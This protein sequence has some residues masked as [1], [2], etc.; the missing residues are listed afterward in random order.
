MLINEIL[1]PITKKAFTTV[2]KIAKAV[3]LY[4][5]RA[6]V[7]NLKPL[8]RLDPIAAR[9]ELTIMLSQLKRFEDEFPQVKEVISF[10]ESQQHSSSPNQVLQMA[11]D[12][13]RKITN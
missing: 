2:P 13:I 11:V 4:K 6:V 10:I 1:G 8:D 3:D 7:N 9:N 12:M 5:L